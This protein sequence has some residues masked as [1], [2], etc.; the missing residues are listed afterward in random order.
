MGTSTAAKVGEDRSI[1]DT[2]FRSPGVRGVRRVGRTSARPPNR[3]TAAFRRERHSVEVSLT[4]PRDPAAAGIARHELARSLG[5]ALGARLGDLELVISE[6]VTNAVRHGRGEI[7]LA[8]LLDG[9]QVQGH[10]ID[11]GHGFSRT[12]SARQLAGD[13]GFGLGIVEQLTSH[14]DVRN[15]TSDVSFELDLATESR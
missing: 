6:L 2:G 12:D 13:G 4:L 3:H 8:V 15:G 9:T 5:E 14:W 1:T 10:V 11:D 7:R